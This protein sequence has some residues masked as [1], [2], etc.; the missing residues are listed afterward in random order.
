MIT[1]N[2]LQNKLSNITNAL[3]SLLQSDLERI[4]DVTE[5]IHK[6]AE[7]LAIENHPGV[8]ISPADIMQGLYVEEEHRRMIDEMARKYEEIQ[9]DMDKLAKWQEVTSSELDKYYGLGASESTIKSLFSDRWFCQSVCE[10]CESVSLVGT[11]GLVT[12]DMSKVY[13][14]ELESFCLTD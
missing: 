14:V 1:Y 8:I 11:T 13:M 9:S 10:A 3:N 4:Q 12:G 5:L 7:D 6:K 2:S